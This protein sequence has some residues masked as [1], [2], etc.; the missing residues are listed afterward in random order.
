MQQTELENKPEI[1]EDAPVLSMYDHSDLVLDDKN[2]FLKIMSEHGAQNNAF[3]P[4]KYWVYN[5]QQLRL[6]EMGFDR[7]EDAALEMDTQLPAK[8][9]DLQQE[10]EAYH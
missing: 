6:N 1:D 3:L 8:E 4:Y 10:L 2:V 9:E 5:Y 7:I